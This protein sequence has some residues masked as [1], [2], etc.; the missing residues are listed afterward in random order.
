MS[1]SATAEPPVLDAAGVREAMAYY[2]SW[3]AFQQRCQRVPGVQAAVR[4]SDELVHASAH[5]MAD[6]ERAVPLT[7]SHLFRI[8]SH[9]KT[10]TATAV[11]QLAQRGTLRLDD[12]A[13]QWVPF[14][15]EHGSPFAEATLRELLGHASGMS[16]DSSD[17]DHW[18]LWRE[19]PDRDGLRDRLLAADARVLPRNERFKYSNLAYS[20]LGLVIEAASGTSYAEA[21]R[22]TI[23]DPLGLRDT[24]PEL[25]TGRLGEL[26]VGYSSLAYA[27]TRVPVEHIDTGAMAAATG[28]YS[29]AHDMVDYFAAHFLGNDLLLD[30][31][32]KRQMQHPAW[33]VGKKDSKYG[34]GL[35][36]VTVGQRTLVGHGGGF[37]GHI[38]NTIAD[39]RARLAVSVLTNA[40]DGPADELAETAVRLVDL[41]CA[42][43][44]AARTEQEADLPSFTGRFASLWGV[45]DVA[46][47]GGR[48]F[49]LDPSAADPVEDAVPLAVVDAVTLRYD[50]GSGYGSYGE[51]L[52]YER[53]QAGNIRSVRAASG[54]TL[55]PLDRFELPVKV[56][57]GNP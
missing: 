42:G 19:F 3:L 21:V 10:F 44:P 13:G 34:L 35:A 47:L 2:G 23:I 18:Q 36:V 26:A 30:D 40:I 6:V 55:T 56:T 8:A 51:P 25:D 50:G 46:L 5:G 20:L 54:T 39:T 41:A 28:F 29:T 31:D 16:R 45:T 57:L 48:L 33:E 49:Q 12:P 43:R 11:L 37:P 17:G 4:F 1:E 7:E 27:D 24:G 22:A 9:S 52:A 14:L 53:D 15:R 32:W 38:T